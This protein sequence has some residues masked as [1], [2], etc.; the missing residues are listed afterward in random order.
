MKLPD[1]AP[2]PPSQRVALAAMLA[3][4]NPTQT[5]WLRGF[6]TTSGTSDGSA[7]PLPLPPA[8]GKKNPYPARLNRRH[9]LNRPGSAKETWHLEFDIAGSGMDYEPGDALGLIP[10]NAPDVVDAV[11]AASG[12]R[13]DAMVDLKEIGRVTLREAFTDHLDITGIN[14]VILARYN[15]LAKSEK[16]ASLL[17]PST[18]DSLGSFLRGRQLIDILEIFP[19]PGL[20][21]QDL[22]G[23]LRKMPPRLYS[24]ASSLKAH[25]GEVHLTIAAVRYESHGKMRKGVASTFIADILPEHGTTRVF[26]HTNKNFKLPPSGDTPIIMVGPGT[27]IAPFRAFVEERAANGD[28]GKNWLFFG[29]Q[30][31]ACDFLYQNEWQEFVGSGVLTRFDTAFSRDQ[32]EKIYVQHRMLDHARELWAWLAEGAH[33]YVCGDASRMAADVHAA[34]IQIALQQG[35]LNHD[36]AEAY[37]ENLRKMKRYQRDVY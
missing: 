4:L 17:D 27:G 36:E 20:D 9:R 29:D 15:L 23:V 25:P 7:G 8:F 32:Q 24:I 26:V 28:K 19:V 12:L 3:D 11:L 6:L 22:A 14:S 33:I 37:F 30:H 5:A 16:L 13:G 1:S 35:G 18:T 10:S 31:A 34:L 21:C 2:F